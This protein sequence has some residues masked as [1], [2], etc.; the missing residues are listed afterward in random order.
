MEDY[1]D[2]NIC[3][4]GDYFTAQEIL[5]DI[6]NH[7]GAIPKS[8]FL[9]EQYRKDLEKYEAA[10]DNNRKIINK[11]LTES[12]PIKMQFL[13]DLP[14]TKTPS[15]EERVIGSV[16]NV[17]NT[18]IFVK[19]ETGRIINYYKKQKINIEKIIEQ[20]E[21]VQ[22]DRLLLN[23]I[24]TK[25]LL[26]PQLDAVGIRGI[27]TYINREQPNLDMTDHVLPM[28][29]FTLKKLATME[30]GILLLT[31]S[32][33]TENINDMK[34]GK[35][36]TMPTNLYE[37]YKAG[38]LS[39]YIGYIFRNALCLNETNSSDPLKMGF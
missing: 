19:R 17:D 10:K 25:L 37:A 9:K 12:N 26:L 39:E 23:R 3:M 13:E 6:V 21:G 38:R 7:P 4:E 22:Y 34:S 2:E 33:I 32:K 36:T 5:K 29:T 1:L 11:Y 18:L 14:Q 31:H 30:T 15:K 27:I 24:M 35:Y 8:P 16:A 28:L 20:Q